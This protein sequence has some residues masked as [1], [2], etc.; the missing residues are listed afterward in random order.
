[1]T[2]SSAL[3]IESSFAIYPREI[4]YDFDDILVSTVYSGTFLCSF[5][6]QFHALLFS[7]FVC[8]DLLF[9]NLVLLYVCCSSLCFLLPWMS[10]AIISKIVQ[11]PTCDL[12][13]SREHVLILW[14]RGLLGKLSKFI[15]KYV[16]CAFNHQRI[17]KTKSWSII[18]PCWL[19]LIIATKAPAA[20]AATSGSI[21]YILTSKIGASEVNFTAIT[22]SIFSAFSVLHS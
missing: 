16:C 3:R 6:W 13:P 1:M 10:C 4:S 20:V 15:Q 12:W 21:V 18:L 19:D 7:I 22:C 17:F 9:R 5:I 2:G 14:K 8:F 11:V